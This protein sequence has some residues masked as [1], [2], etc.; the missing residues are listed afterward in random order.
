MAKCILAVTLLLWFPNVDGNGGEESAAFFTE[1]GSVDFA[2]GPDSILEIANDN[3]AG[4]SANR[5][6]EFVLFD[7]LDVHGGDDQYV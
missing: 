7:S 6:L 2:V 3:D 1:Y 5:Q 4:F